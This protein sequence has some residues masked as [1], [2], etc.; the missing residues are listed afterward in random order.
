MMLEWIHVQ[1]QLRQICTPATYDLVPNPNTV[2]SLIE[3]IAPKFY[4]HMCGGSDCGRGVRQFQSNVSICAMRND[5]CVFPCVTTPG[6]SDFTAFN[7][8][9][10]Y[11][12]NCVNMSFF[13]V[14]F[15][16]FIILL[17]FLRKYLW[18]CWLFYFS[19][20]FVLNLMS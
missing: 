12:Q 18:I 20:W 16:L 10:W 1:P 5:F 15:A 11:A 6:M 19:H 13:Y 17:L 14:L 2:W 8:L 9:S 3:S 7:L 4:S